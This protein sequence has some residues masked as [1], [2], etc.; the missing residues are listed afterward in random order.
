M[1]KVIYFLAM[2][3][4]VVSCASDSKGGGGKKGNSPDNFNRKEMLTFWADKII[5]PGYAD[6][7]SKTKSLEEAVTT[8]TITPSVENLTKARSAWK[9]AYIVW[10]KVSLFQIGKAQEE[11]MTGSMNTYPTDTEAIK[12]YATKQNYNFESPNL[13]DKQGFPALDYLLNGQGTNQKTINFYTKAKNASKYKKYLK[14]VA[15]RIN[16]LTSKVYKSWTNGYRNT[17]INNDGYTATSSVDKLVNFYV[18][19]FYEKQFREPKIATP[20]GVRTSIPAPEKAEAYYA[21]NF[22][23]QLYMVTLEATK[24][25]FKGIGYDGKTQGKSLQQYLEF[26]KRKDLA[27]LINTNFDKL[28]K[29]SESLDD[30]FT[31]KF[32]VK[33]DEKGQ[34]IETVIIDKAKR[35]KM[36]NTFDAIQVILKNFKPDMMSAMS[37]RN[38]STDTDND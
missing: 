30:N 8:F 25:F 2:C 36:L 20:A 28:T 18:I 19:P 13:N 11:N 35:S 10:Q 1:K 29:L 26:L 12:T 34:V 6:F 17:F 15:V 5:I 32:E 9:E 37:V 14:D 21:K 31:I 16:L 23:K 7:S 27:N 33:K 38:T 3:L 24:N 4:L 22:S